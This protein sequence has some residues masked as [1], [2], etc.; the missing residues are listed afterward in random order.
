[1]DNKKRI[2]FFLVCITLLGAFFRLFHIN[3]Q[4]LWSEELYAIIL[5]D[6]KNHILSLTDVARSTG[7][8]AFYMFL[9]GV[10]KIFYYEDVVG[11]VACAIIG[12]IAIPVF[13]FLVKEFD[14]PKTGLFA[15]LLVA[16]NYWHIY[17]SQELNHYSMAFLFS[18]LSY[19][20]L[21]R[22]Y[23][24]TRELDF[25]GYVIFTALLLNTHSFGFILFG[26]QI[27]TIFLLIRFYKSEKKFREG[28]VVGAITILILAPWG[29]FL[30]TDL[31][32]GY[33]WMPHPKFYFILAYL[34]NYFG[35]D[36]LITLIYVILIGVFF[37]TILKK[38]TTEE[39]Q[40]PLYL[41][42][43][44]WLVLPYAITF[45][46]SLFGNSILDI[47][48]TIVFL[49]AWLMVLAIGWA[50]INNTK[51]KFILVACI[52]FSS[53]INLFVFKKYYTTVHKQQMRE[54]S[55]LVKTKNI[56]SDPVYSKLSW[57]FNFYFR[58]AR[59]KV[60]P[61]DSLRYDSLTLKGEN[62]F[63]LLQLES[64]QE[65][66]DKLT[67][68]FKIIENYSFHHANAFLIQKNS[69]IK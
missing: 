30:I 24:Y 69:K 25:A 44:L 31:F 64:S 8:Q 60:I 53:L 15:S 12:I 18:A 62:K 26:V 47:R 34:Y 41:I 36:V 19:L 4:S 68:E 20:F 17:Y 3:F 51:W 28:F 22:A 63:W 37:K 35:K 13:Y 33:P 54:V 29:N 23:K 9:Y 7:S 27:I 61:L 5:T 49:P 58:D 2:T 59:K 56:S 48:F 55:Q 39:K 43:I 38:N 42:L 66:L 1:M 40:K 14:E 21:T 11:R 16:V 52:T 10:F 57:E 45:I 50:N 6:P 46:M 32:T 65:E 67:D